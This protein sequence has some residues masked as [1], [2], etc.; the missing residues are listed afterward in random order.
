MDNLEKYL[1]QVM[2]PKPV[3]YEAPS[4][5]MPE[6]ESGAKPNLLM[7]VARRWYIILATTIVLCAVGLPVL[8]L[9]I[10]PTYRVT[11]AIQV[12]PRENILTGT[13]LAD[14]G[15]RDFI[16][17]L[18]NRLQSDP[19][20]LNAV[21]RSLSYRELTFFSG[22][23]QTLPEKLLARIRPMR[24]R[25]D[26]VQVLSEALSDG[27][28][29]VR[30]LPNSQYITINMES[31][32]PEEAREIIEQWVHNY[33]ERYNRDADQAGAENRKTLENE[34]DQLFNNMEVRREEIR[35]RAE[36]Y[37]SVSLDGLYEME[38]SRQAALVNDLINLQSQ[39]TALQ[40]R[41]NR[42][43]PND[44]ASMTPERLLAARTES[45]NSDPTVVAL[46][47]QIAQ[48]RRD[49]I[50]LR[51]ARRPGNPLL[52]HHEGILAGLEEALAERMAE[53]EANFDGGV[54]DRWRTLV[55]QQRENAQA[56]LA[57]V[58]AAIEARRELLRQQTAATI[59]IGNAKLQIDNLQHDLNLMKSTYDTIAQR[60]NRIEVQGQVR[61]EVLWGYR[62]N[63]TSTR[64]KRPQYSAGVL[65]FAMGC[66]FALA[67]LRDKM[68]KTL[69]TPDDLTRCLDLPVLG[70]TSS[71]HT[72]KPSLFAEQIAADYQTIR[73]NL[74]L[75][76]NGGIPRK[77]AVSSPGVREGKTTFAVN[78]ATSLAKSG[79]RV[80]L[81][82][83][84]LR[85]P[86][87]RYMLNVTN[88]KSG[89]QDVLMGASA[90]KAISS[91]S[92]SGLH[93]LAAHT[94]NTGDVYELLVSSRAAEQVERLGREYDH[95]IVDT[96]P[97]LAFPDALIWARMAGAVVLVGFA[98]QTTG[99]ELKDAREKFAR[100]RVNVLGVILSNVRAEQNTYRYGYSR[101]TTDVESLRKSRQQRKLL[102]SP[103]GRN[104]PTEKAGHS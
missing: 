94:R 90:E 83:G 104:E 36:E 55:G 100:I 44:A 47:Q 35:E 24:G 14:G 30:P 43:D 93:V 84:D 46:S 99:P 88:G 64:D 42:L 25:V 54:G 6:E 61:P 10:E 91:I 75:L 67:L 65:F 78:L 23:P 79:K 11:G 82:D 98:G 53:L 62:P 97:V 33:L 69:Q 20:L 38:L 71:S 3:S 70:T 51:Q 101:R 73:T 95:V 22:E 39:E 80:L 66:G 12:R 81:I 21:V 77:L 4:E 2:E 87:V 74:G 92:A 52:V 27:T 60:L 34:R 89:V 76:T 50:E 32:R 57:E 58:R 103:Q 13:P 29:V 28:I 48:K 40:A 18:A 15:M 31:P 86:D 63:I 26:P 102:L 56:E 49:L 7:A 5:F 37:G 1:D 8:W 72:V 59:K 68:D 19:D 96:P 85:K 17:T 41:L 45:V 16:N 9:S